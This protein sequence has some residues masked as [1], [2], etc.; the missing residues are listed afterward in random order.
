MDLRF[1]QRVPAQLAGLGECRTHGKEDRHWREG[2]GDAEIVVD[3]R[4]RE[5][6]VRREREFCAH[7]PREEAGDPGQRV[8]GLHQAE[9]LGLGQLVGGVHSTIKSHR[10]RVER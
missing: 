5:G 10:E 3:P 4:E 2:L 7:C 1:S 8:P 9:L 6:R